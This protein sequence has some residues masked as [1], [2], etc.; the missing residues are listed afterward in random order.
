MRRNLSTCR[1]IIATLALL[2]SLVVAA[3]AQNKLTSPK[4]QFGFNIGDDY[5]LVN[6]T[7]YEA[8]LKKLDEE[9]DRLK[10]LEM[11]KSAEGRTMYLAVIT[12]PENHKNLARYKEISRRLALAEGLTDEQARELA[13]EGKS[14]VWIDGG[15]HA[16]EVLGAHQLIE[17][18]YQLV[19]RNDDETKRILR[20]CIVIAVQVNP[21]GMELVSNWYM[22]EP[23]TLK[24][25][26]GTI[27]RL[28]QKY[29][30]HDDN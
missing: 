14:V 5:Q 9:S 15:L 12:S 7:Q 28:Y 21:D 22:Q 18:S 3:A 11:G 8:Y 10:V 19:S 30:G 6:Y 16:T 20:D 2:G 24:R 1:H 29:I 25:T 4:D 26:F 27:P 23:D 17:T 13:K